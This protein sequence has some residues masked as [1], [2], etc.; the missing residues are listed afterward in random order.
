MCILVKA[1]ALLFLSDSTLGY[2]LFAKQAGR[3]T[4]VVT[5]V[6]VAAV[7]AWSVML[8]GI[9]SVEQVDLYASLQTVAFI[10]LKL[11][12]IKGGELSHPVVSTV[13]VPKASSIWINS[14][15]PVVGRLVPESM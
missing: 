15:A 9:V 11:G 5:G 1:L 3:L 4:E 13:T 2:S 14:S 10:Y 6:F 7:I 8:I 12:T